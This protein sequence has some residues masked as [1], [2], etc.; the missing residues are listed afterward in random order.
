LA[1]GA[2]YELFPTLFFPDPDMQHALDPA[3]PNSLF[4]VPSW[5][6]TR[7]GGPY[8]ILSN[9]WFNIFLDN[10]GV[11]T[12]IISGDKFRAISLVTDTYA[13]WNSN[14]DGNHKP[15]YNWTS[16]DVSL[17]QPLGPPVFTGPYIRRDYQYGSVEIEITSGRYPDSIDYRIWL[18]GELV[19]ELAVP[20]HTP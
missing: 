3:Y 1:D 9:V 7:N 10:N 19:S 8:L 5:Y 20:Y 17:G 2:F 4:N 15:V 12:P 18:L 11:P 16:H 6:R 13:A 14:P